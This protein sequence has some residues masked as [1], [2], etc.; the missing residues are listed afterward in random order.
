VSTKRANEETRSAPADDEDAPWVERFVAGERAAFDE[1]MRR[2]ERSVYFLAMRYLRDHDEAADILQRTFLKAFEKLAEFEGRS[3][4]RTWL[5]RI[6]INLCKNRL[7]DQGRWQKVDPEEDE[8]LVAPAKEDHLEAEQKQ[9]ALS[10]A[11][12]RLPPK[13]RQTLELRVF[14]EMSFREIADAMG[15]TENAAKVNYHYA[16]KNLLKIQGQ[17]S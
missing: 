5:F 10:D 4:F 11:V 1:L 3:Q 12:D 8:L 2:H 15:C 7:R 6:A 17:S 16:V 13:Q 14:G 9:A